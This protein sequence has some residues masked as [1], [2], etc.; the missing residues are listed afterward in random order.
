MSSAL[1]LAPQIGIGSACK[2]M[3]VP[4]ASLYRSLRPRT[5]RIRTPRPRPARSLSTAETAH[6]LEVLNSER[7]ADRSPAEVYATLLDE[8]TYLCSLRTMYRVLAGAGEVRERRNQLR[9]P[10]YAKPE[11]LATRPNQVWS[12]DITKLRGPGKWN[13]Y[14]LY[15][16][17][18]IYSRYVVGWM[19]AEGE[20]ATLA[21][22]LI[23]DTCA[24]E[25]IAPGTL[26]IHA[27]RGSAMT[28]KSVALLCTDLGVDRTH[29]RPHVSDDNPYSESQFKTLKYQPSFPDR[30]GSIQHARGFCQDFFPWYNLEHRHS[31][32]AMLTPYDMHY[33][34]AQ[35]VVEQRRVVLARAYQER[36][37]RFVGGLPTP[38]TAPTEAW[39]NRPESRPTIEH[40]EPSKTQTICAPTL[41]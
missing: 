19:V 5:E 29:S 31:G 8:G 10:T 18:D 6:V 38:E 3:S 15:V 41:Q 25:K 17:L 24:K 1:E 39:I 7:F 16:I 28:S 37:E 11:L 30:F 20:S 2:A 13:Y 34:R 40:T 22:Q 35:A 36:P 26:K 32:I 4:R 27:D 14:A 12:W 9:H 23:A 21:E 33:G